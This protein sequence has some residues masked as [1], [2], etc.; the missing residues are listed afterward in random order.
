M[1]L[2]LTIS[3]NRPIDGRWVGGQRNK[4]GCKSVPNNIFDD[5]GV[6]GRF[7]GVFGHIHQCKSSVIVMAGFGIGVYLLVSHR[8]SI[9]SSSGNR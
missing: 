8:S 9:R 4:N 5:F 3:L 1:I 7:G 2:L 6:Y